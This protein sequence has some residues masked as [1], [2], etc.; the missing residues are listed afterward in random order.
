MAS[1]G[2]SQLDRDAYRNRNIVE[3]CFGRLKEYRRTLRQNGEELSGD[4][5]T[6]L[7]PTVLQKVMQLRDT[8]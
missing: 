3:R 7:Y 2:R 5:L 1:D 8:A 4:G 6:G